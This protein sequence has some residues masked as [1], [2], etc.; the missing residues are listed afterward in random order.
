MPG[1]LPA[2]VGN[3]GNEEDEYT[4]ATV[5]VADTVAADADPT[6]VSNVAV[7]NAKS[8]RICVPEKPLPN[9]E[10]YAPTRTPQLKS[11]D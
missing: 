2:P 3:T 7:A 1:E 6:V 11:T 10:I 5:Y 9:M 8:T 4:S